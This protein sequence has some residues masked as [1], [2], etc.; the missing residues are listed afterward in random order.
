MANNE[1]YWIRTTK[2][3]EDKD[4][5]QITFTMYADKDYKKNLTTLIG[6]ANRETK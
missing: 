2:E 1:W 5:R 6:Y 4:A 3:T